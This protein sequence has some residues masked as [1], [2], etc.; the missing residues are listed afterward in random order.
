MPPGISRP[1]LRNLEDLF[2]PALRSCG[3]VAELKRVHARIVRRSLSQSNFL[4]TK[5]VDVCDRCGDLGYAISLFRSAAGPNVF[6]YNAIVRACARNFAYGLVFAVYREMLEDGKISPDEFTFP[7]LIK[8][9]GGLGS[10][11]L[12]SQVHAHVCKFGAAG[13]L[14]TENSL[15]DMYAKFG[16]LEDAYK[17]FDEMPQ[18]DAVSWNGLISGHVRS[19]EVMR[20]RELFDEMPC[21]TVVSWTTVISG[22]SQVGCYVDALEIFRQMQTVGVEPDEISIVSV[23][24][25]CAHLG[26]L[27]VGKWIHMYADKHRLLH[28]TCICNAL[29]EMYAKCG[30][31]EQASRLFNEMKTRDVISWSTMICS[32]ANHG[33]AHE[34]I[35][36]FQAMRR[37]GVDPNGVTFLGTL[38]AC[39][40]AGLVDEGMELFCSMKRDYEL[41]PDIEHYGC[42]IDLLGRSGCLDQAMD[43]VQT[44][45]MKPDSKIWGS[46]LSSC[47]THGN[48]EMAIAA[49]EHLIELEPDFTGN[50]V[51]LANLYA[52]LGK[53]EGVSRM[54]K[55]MRNR[56]LKKPP[57][58]S[59]IEVD[60]MVLEFVS[61]DNS[62]PFSGDAYRMIELLE[63]ERNLIL[64]RVQADVH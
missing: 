3:N 59:S 60:N 57:G 56:N 10:E 22:Y 42:L 40:H 36:L 55:L 26:A 43:V 64:Q 6:L 50:Y 32:L 18:R 58:G 33:K 25:A 38:S 48:L 9:C 41:E 15:I 1:V 29:M 24:P 16:K 2:V 4:A 27:E 39:V 14:V 35:E 20:A 63:L 54:R 52:D 46:L 13:Q 19:G 5:M 31:I 11:H 23:L 45:P 51:L 34:A 7:F 28:R 12:G 61:G 49:M 8:S 17:V 53:S 21:K 37:A 62:K 44:M 47:R 30:C